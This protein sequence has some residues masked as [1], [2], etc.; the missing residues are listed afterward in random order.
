MNYFFVRRSSSKSQ[1]QTTQNGLKYNN[2]KRINKN[3]QEVGY[4][5]M[6]TVSY[7]LA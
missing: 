5:E 2:Y 7:E 6:P 3:K 1:T 4:S